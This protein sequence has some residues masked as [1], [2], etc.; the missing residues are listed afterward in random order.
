M[1]LKSNVSQVNSEKVWKEGAQV[2]MDMALNSLKKT[3]RN[4]SSRYKES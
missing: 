3:A 4:P 2:K 1:I